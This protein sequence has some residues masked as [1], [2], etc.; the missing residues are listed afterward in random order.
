[1]SYRRD[2]FERMNPINRKTIEELHRL[3]MITVRY[4]SNIQSV[5]DKDGKPLVHFVE[6][7]TPLVFDTIVYALGGSSPRQ[8]LESIGI[9]F[10]GHQP[11]V[12]DG[13]ETNIPGIFLVGDLVHY[14]KGGSIITAFNSA[15]RAM[16]AICDRYLGCTPRKV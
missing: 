14:P 1:M 11:L 8:F 10:D 6:P 9:A 3:N 13:F 5:E 7:P 2:S 12:T 15:H 16:E 4:N